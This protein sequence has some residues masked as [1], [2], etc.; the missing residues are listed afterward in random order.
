MKLHMREGMNDSINYNIIQILKQIG[1]DYNV[2]ID[3][4]PIDEGYVEFVIRYPDDDSD[5]YTMDFYQNSLR[6][7]SNVTDEVKRFES[8]AEFRDSIIN[9]VESRLDLINS[10][11]WDYDE[12]W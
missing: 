1:N 11:R 3:T 2:E 12:E 10:D 6:L 4:Q 9:D 8:L 7:A 5:V